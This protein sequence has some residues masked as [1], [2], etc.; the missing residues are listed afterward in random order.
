MD[1]QGAARVGMFPVELAVG[2]RVAV[3]TRLEGTWA[4]GFEII[5]HVVEDQRVAAYRLRRVS[6]GAVLPISFA[7]PDVIAADR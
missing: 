6:D 4:G 3:R 1:A 5:G 2:T 7:H